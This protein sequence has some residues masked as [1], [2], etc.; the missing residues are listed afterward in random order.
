VC[1]Q[2]RYVTLSLAPTNDN[3][4][5]NMPDVMCAP[6]RTETILLF[7]EL[8]FLRAFVGLHI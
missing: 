8:Q 5:P 7:L 6:S 4:N 2:A 3:N 1:S